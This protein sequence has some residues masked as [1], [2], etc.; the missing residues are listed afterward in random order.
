[1]YSATFLKNCKA[2]FKVKQKIDISQLYL[3]VPLSNKMIFLAILL[4]PILL[5]SICRAENEY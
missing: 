5:I 3:M 2:E 1:M 4:P